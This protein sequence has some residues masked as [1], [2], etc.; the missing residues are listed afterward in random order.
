MIRPAVRISLLKEARSFSLQKSYV[1]AE[2]RARQILER[3]VEGD[4]HAVLLD[5]KTQEICICH[6]LVTVDPRSE[7]SGKSHPTLIDRTIAI[8]G[9]TL[10]GLKNGDCE[11]QRARARAKCGIRRHS[12]KSCLR[13]RT[14]GPVQ[15]ARGSEPVPRL[16][17]ML[18]LGIRERY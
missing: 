18:M 8:A 17:V 3:L 15:F 1:S 6:L 16:L 7:P 10:K 13:K 5:R 4:Q 14:D 11:L 9:I 12:Q 2:L